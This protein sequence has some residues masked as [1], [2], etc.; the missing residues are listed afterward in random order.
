MSDSTLSFASSSSFRNTL[1]GRNLPPYNVNGVYTPPATDVNYPT[2]LSDS[3]VIDSP[4]ELISNSPFAVQAYVLNEFGPDGGYN[5]NISY[6]GPA[7][8]VNSN[9]GEY[10]PNETQMDILNEQ[11]IDAAFTQNP[12]GPV[13]GFNAMV[14]ITDL[15][16]EQ[17]YYQP[18][19]Y[20]PNFVPSS[21]SNIVPPVA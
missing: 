11:F 13:G 4:D 20:P 10:S 9:Q 18:Y 21:Y 6:N 1:M 2:I 19:W 16:F 5:Q 12:Y 17:Y 15:T 7:L 14:E 8:P 3:N